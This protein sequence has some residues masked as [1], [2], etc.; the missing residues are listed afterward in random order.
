MYGRM[1]I[2]GMRYNIIPIFRKT[3]NIKLQNI[4]VQYFYTYKTYSHVCE[5]RLCLSNANPLIFAAR[6][7]LNV[8]YYIHYL[9]VYI[10]NG[11]LAAHVGTFFIWLVLHF[12]ITIQKIVLFICIYKLRCLYSVD[13]NILIYSIELKARKYRFT[14]MK[15]LCRVPTLEIEVG[16][17][18]YYH[19][20]N[21]Y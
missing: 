8:L 12:Q 13:I 20:Q 4:N 14:Q 1:C 11:Q 9:F 5:G 17:S 15:H 2:R 21:S 6:V 3:V 16:F 19:P 18:A 7:D 10:R